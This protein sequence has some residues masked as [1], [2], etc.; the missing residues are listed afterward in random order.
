MDTTAV[1]SMRDSLE[2]MRARG[3]TAG[4]RALRQRMQAAGPGR[5]QGGRGRGPGGQ[6]PGEINL[7]PAEAPPGQQGQGGGGGGGRFGGQRAGAAV[8][9]GDY[10]VT[11]T[12]AS[13]Q[14]LKRVIH[15]ERIGEI[16]EDTGFFGDNGFEDEEGE[17]H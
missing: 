10:L 9:E 7:R 2:A 3:D 14:T 11:I 1:R 6:Q 8:P 5:G 4:M 13:G 12:T 15:V 17:E 16:P